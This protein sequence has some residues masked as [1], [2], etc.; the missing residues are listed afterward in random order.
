MLHP[1]RKKSVEQSLQTNLPCPPLLYSRALHYALLIFLPEATLAVLKG[2]QIHICSPEHAIC[3]VTAGSMPSVDP[4]NMAILL[5]HTHIHTL[6]TKLSLVIN[7]HSTT[8]FQQ[9]Y[10]PAFFMYSHLK[11][12]SN[13]PFASM[14]TTQQLDQASPNPAGMCFIR[15]KTYISKDLSHRIQICAQHALNTHFLVCLPQRGFKGPSRFIHPGSSKSNSH[16]P[17]AGLHI[18][19]HACTLQV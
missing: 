3:H 11:E 17:H 9:K 2:T 12:Q 15:F 14:H 18:R 16:G 7:Q 1:F 10:H 5:M 13:R 4:Q 6:L 19:G 8:S